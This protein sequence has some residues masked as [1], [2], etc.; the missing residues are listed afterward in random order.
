MN[1][2]PIR[3]GIY[4]NNALIPDV[5]LSQPELGNPGCGGTEY[6]MS[7]LPY[8]FQKHLNSQ[9]ISTLFANNIEKLP[10]NI[11]SIKANDLYSAA[12]KAKESH[13]DFFIYRPHRSL[14][15][16]FLSLI[17]QLQLPTI[18]WIHVTPKH[19]HNRAL[20]RNP[21]IRAFV[22]VEHEQY[23][24]LQ[25]TP[26]YPKLTYIVN[27]FDLQGFQ[28]QESIAKEP[29]LVVYLGAL[30]PQKGFHLLAK[31]WPDVVQRIPEAKLAVIGSGK[32]Y[33]PSL[34]MGPWGIAGQSYEQTGIIPFLQDGSG[35]PMKSVSFLGRLGLEKKIWLSKAS[36]G[37]ANPSG[38][39]EH[40]PGS[41][42][43]IQASGTAIVSGAYYGML[44][45]IQHNKTGLL[46]RGHQQ[47]V[48]NI[49]RVLQDSN[50]RIAL[51]NR[52][53]QF[54]EHRYN[55]AKVTQQW[56]QLFLKLRENEFP[57][58]IGFKRNLHQHQKWLIQ[59]NKPLQQRFGQT[60]KWPSVFEISHSVASLLKKEGTW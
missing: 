39:S 19:E 56:Q 8:Y 18:A 50:L 9:I 33:D 26:L 10:P 24:L 13:C 42:L 14:N 60:I 48:S 40:C 21:F 17:E 2:S 55:Y 43:E 6:L 58:R 4:L 37:V 15:V 45:T 57:S 36:V 51:Q 3:I 52:G 5:D 20:A 44:D 23:D 29:N 49:C 35:S 54:V 16:Q 59:L 27:G 28:L 53:P 1:F 25:D 41:A 32:L 38:Q 11:H 30:V 7:A 34:K 12:Q 46:G 22:C 31:A 47:L